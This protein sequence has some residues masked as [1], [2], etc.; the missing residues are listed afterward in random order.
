VHITAQGPRLRNDLHC[1]ELDVKLYYTIPIAIY[2]ARSIIAQII[3]SCRILLVA[4][5]FEK[6]IRKLIASSLYQ[7]LFSPYPSKKKNN[8]NPPKR[9]ELFWFTYS[10]NWTEFV[11]YFAEL[12]NNSKGRVMRRRGLSL[13]NFACRLRG[14]LIILFVHSMGVY[15]GGKLGDLDRW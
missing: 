13:R 9:F 7:I 5:A 8:R 15:P 10:A 14:R 6:K 12:S 4:S 3:H 2:V 1:V 11:S